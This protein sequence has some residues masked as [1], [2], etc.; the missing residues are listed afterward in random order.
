M[1][2]SDFLAP[3]FHAAT[4]LS[5]LPHRH[6]TLEDLR[7]ELRDRSTAIS[8]ELLELVNANYTA[9]LSL[10]NDLR[11]GDEK[12][13]DV[14]VAML[15]FR[16]AI[17]EVKERVRARGKDVQDLSGELRGVRRDIEM[18]RR[19]LELGERLSALEDRLTLGGIGKTSSQDDWFA[20]DSDEE[21]EE[22]GENF[23][24]LLGSSPS[25]LMGLT[26]E[27]VHVETLADMVGRDKPFVAK[28]EARMISCRNTILLD[29]GTALK[30]AKKA[31]ERGRLRLV[32]YLGIYSSLGA[33][34]EAIQSLKVK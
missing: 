9:F 20:N 10:G 11:G 25:K 3:D 1:P 22:E 15:G 28:M 27:Y 4:Y 29:L 26:R 32:K 31:G 30:E 8:A 13:E 5:N 17:E 19:M 33:E 14:K 12:V 2:R 21:E 6:Q 23:D 16:R 7:S 24:G 18:G 34:A